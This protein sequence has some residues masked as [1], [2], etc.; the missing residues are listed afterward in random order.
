MAFYTST[1]FL[2]REGHSTILALTEI[3][4]HIYDA[5]DKG[6]YALGLYLDL[7]KAFDMV[8]HHNL[9]DKL[10][11]YGIRGVVHEWFRSYLTN[12]KQYVYVN[13]TKSQVMEVAK[14]VP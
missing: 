14:G 10:Y 12:C 2:F 9:L 8:C 1:N 7:T 4:E 3:T 11:H 6:K 5:L 13:E